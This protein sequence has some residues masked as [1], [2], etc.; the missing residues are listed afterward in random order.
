MD[1]NQLALY[2]LLVIVAASVCFLVWVFYHL[3]GDA[4]KRHK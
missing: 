4:R 1:P 3:E 2:I